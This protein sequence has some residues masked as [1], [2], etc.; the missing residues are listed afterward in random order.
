MARGVHAAARVRQVTWA[1]QGFIFLV[2]TQAYK[3]FAYDTAP[4]EGQIT[5]M[6]GVHLVLMFSPFLLAQITPLMAITP[7][8]FLRDGARVEVHEGGL[9]YT[10]DAV[11]R[12]LFVRWEDLEHLQQTRFG[13]I[14]RTRGGAELLDGLPKFQAEFWGAR[15][16]KPIHLRY[17]ERFEPQGAFLQCLQAARRAG[18]QVE[19]FEPT[20]NKAL[21]TT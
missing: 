21:V 16:K 13:L 5:W 19:G 3:V 1:T 7:P 10:F 18:V 2:I 14:F 11:K 8:L 4:G 20:V 17:V 15:I 6:T 12:P 9:I